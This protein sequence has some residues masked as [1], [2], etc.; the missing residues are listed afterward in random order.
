MKVGIRKVFEKL[1]V[2]SLQTPFP[3]GLLKV[4]S[5][6]VSFYAFISPKWKQNKVKTRTNWGLLCFLSFSFPCHSVTQHVLQE[7]TGFAFL[8]LL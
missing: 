4:C 7:L 2:G 3:V 1:Y 8:K 5:A 6:L